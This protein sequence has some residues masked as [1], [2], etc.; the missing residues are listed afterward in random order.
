[1]YEKKIR[2]V[3]SASIWLFLE[4]N[5]SNGGGPCLM[6]INVM[7]LLSFELPVFTW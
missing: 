1:M 6:K 4:N 2:L 3:A 7:S 5:V